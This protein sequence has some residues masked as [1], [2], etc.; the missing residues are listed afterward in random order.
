[1]GQ[2]TAGRQGLSKTWEATA[3]LAAHCVR[4]RR[5]SQR[6]GA[7]AAKPSVNAWCAA[8]V[9]CGIREAL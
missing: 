5:A 2:T 9:A 6:E 7:R 4:I 3:L 1:V 8:R